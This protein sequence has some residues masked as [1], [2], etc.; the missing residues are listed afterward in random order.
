MENHDDQ[1]HV[2]EVEAS[3]ASKEGV[4][5]WVL[6][7]GTLLAV[8]LLSVVW[9]VP[10]LTR[11]DMEQEANVSNEISEREEAETNGNSTDSIVGMAEPMPGDE[12][13]IGTNEVEREDG[14]STIEN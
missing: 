9:I 6:L 8:L 14:L 4:G 10:A 11:S 2:S 13:E 1:I 5:R 7:I 3:G 12:P